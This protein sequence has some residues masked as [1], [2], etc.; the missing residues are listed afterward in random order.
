M[1]PND[2]LLD[3]VEIEKLEQDYIKSN[4]VP[5]VKKI[6]EMIDSCVTENFDYLDGEIIVEDF[7]GLYDMTKDITPAALP[8]AEL[9]TIVF[10]V[11]DDEIFEYFIA[12]MEEL[13]KKKFYELKDST[14]LHKEDFTALSA[15]AKSLEH[16]NLAITQKNNLY[17]EQ[18]TKLNEL[19]SLGSKMT[20]DLENHKRE[21]GQ[22]KAKYDK[23]TIDFLS[24]MGVFSTII[25]AVFGGLSQIGAIG[26]NLASTPIT[27]ILMYLSLSSITLISIVFISFNAISKLTG[28]N[29][30]SCSCSIHENCD[31]KI[32]EKHP[33]L[34][35][36]LFFFIDLFLFSIILRASTSS[37]W[38]EPLSSF[39]RF[40]DTEGRVR[41]FIIGTFIVI[42]VVFS[43][44]LYR[45]SFSKQKAKE[46]KE[47]TKS[48]FNGIK[49][50][51][52]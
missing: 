25:F 4:S 42:N 46:N 27:K 20:S 18:K 17:K 30:R 44:I 33:T 40:S 28:M 10:K 7:N 5:F 29:L 24:M 51:F 35:F 2:I 23:L 9:T 3:E 6:Q 41:T 34:S 8:Y 26:D 37:D 13:Y 39:M 1:Q 48:I 47:E 19:D 31:H 14:S 21:L 22:Y 52:V 45:V 43:F 11:N 49:S 12:K 32:Y 38:V 16:L 36:S 15:I 50:F